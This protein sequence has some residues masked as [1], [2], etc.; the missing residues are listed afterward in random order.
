DG[1][2][3][4]KL[5]AGEVVV[6]LRETDGTFTIRFGEGTSIAKE[7]VNAVVAQWVAEHDHIAGTGTD[8]LP[9]ATALFVPLIGSQRTVGAVGIKS[10]DA[11]HFRD[12]EQRRLLEACASLIALSVER[13]QSILEAHDAPLQV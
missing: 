5:H 13:D 7:P 11:L 8:T 9:N 2:Q 12:P 4:A 1:H 6:D 3:L 10:V